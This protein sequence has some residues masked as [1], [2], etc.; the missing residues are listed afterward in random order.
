[1]AGVAGRLPE[2]RPSSG[3]RPIP[4]IPG[5][6]L[7]FCTFGAFFPVARHAFIS[8][9]D[10]AYV[11]DNPHV[12]TGL[13]AENIHWAFTNLDMGY[14]HP[15]AWISHM[16]DCEI[17]G[18]NPAGHHLVNVLLHA[19]NAVTL[20]FLLDRFTGARWPSLIVAALFALH[21][22]R[23]ES[24]AWVSE[25][26]DVLSTLF[27][28]LALWAYSFYT[29]SGRRRDYYI[30]LGI[31]LLG[32]MSKPMLVTFGLLLY[33]WDFWPL[34]R[35][36][37][38]PG[39]L[40]REKFHGWIRSSLFFEKV[41][42][43]LL[44]G[45]SSFTAVLGHIQS[46]N[47]A[48][49][50]KLPILLRFENAALSYWAYIGKILHPVDLSFFYPLHPPEALTAA[51]AAV[52]LAGFTALTVMQ[53]RRR[54]FLLAGWL[55]YLFALLPVIG[56]IQV[57]GQAMA[58][59]YTYIPGIG[60]LLILVWCAEE[61]V[62]H[63]HIRS[64]VVTPI[65][66][67]LFGGLTLLTQ[68][69]LRYWRNSETLYRRAIE[70]DATNILALTNLG[71]EYLA[72]NDFRRAVP[73]YRRALELDPNF[74]PAHYNLAVALARMEKWSEALS[75]FDTA[76]SQRPDFVQGRF[77][78]ASVLAVLGRSREARQAFGE[79][80]QIS[81]DS[82]EMGILIGVS[83]IRM[84][85]REL[86]TDY[87]RKTLERDSSPVEPTASQQVLERIDKALSDKNLKFGMG[88]VR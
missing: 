79:L 50:E 25:R 35:L 66:L 72:K 82:R 71:T 61:T 59:R 21:P 49:V 78:R 84:G 16:I 34:G 20:F 60:I 74:F 56:L 1:M 77:V 80:T 64:W 57:G 48:S 81:P 36:S 33:V 51:L 32:L 24:V 17:F 85:L 14:W 42:F 4:F 88:P 31:F 28:L 58:D 39:D 70:L 76:L 53:I 29:E 43:F 45:F 63:M 55:W 19:S 27:L 75:E 54:P 2:G 44:A 69:Q 62:Q 12:L 47:L 30:S 5:A 87:I 41:P 52:A 86:G 73:L 13:T 3:S 40:P 65:L 11:L 7:F 15:L 67:A 38:L 8:F 83:L 6:L 18:T 68:Q 22:L 46:H 10:L 23:V 9:D 37:G 26:K